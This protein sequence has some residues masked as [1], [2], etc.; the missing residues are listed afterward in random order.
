MTDTAV[1][2]TSEVVTNAVEHA[3]PG[4]V[5]LSA[6]G[7]PDRVRVEVCDD[8][9]VQPVVRPLDEEATSGRGLSMVAALATTWGVTA[10][11]P[12]KAVWFELE[13]QE[14]RVSHRRSGATN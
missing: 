12:G 14:H 10:R 4:P 11:H 2:L 3:G 1:L 8:S 9:D 5:R 7:R 6:D 13:E